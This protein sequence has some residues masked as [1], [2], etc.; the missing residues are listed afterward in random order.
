M[1]IIPIRRLGDIGIITDANPYDLP[2]NALSQ[3]N[4]LSFHNGSISRSPLFKGILETSASAPAFTF[5]FRVSGELDRI[6]IVDEN[7][8]VYTYLGGVETDV[9]PVG[10]TPVV[11]TEPHTFCSL[12]NIGYLNR[13]TDVPMYIT[14][15]A[16]TFTALANWPATY[17]CKALRSFKSYLVALN[18]NKGSS[19]YPTMVKWSDITVTN[20]IPT[21]WDETDP[22]K[23]AGEIP[24]DELTSPLLDGLGLRDAFI[25]YAEDQVHLME[26]TA[27]QSVFRFRKLF[28]GKGIINTNC[29]VEVDGKHFVFGKNDIYVHDGVSSQSIIA[30]K[31]KDFVFNNLN[32]RLSDS[33]FVVHNIALNEIMF[34]YVSGDEYAGYME[35]SL[36]NR[37]AVYNPTNGTWAFRDLPNCSAAT[38]ATYSS[39]STSWASLSGPWD[40][41]GGSWDGFGGAEAYNV[42]FVSNTHTPSGVTADRLLG[43]DTVLNGNINADPLTELNKRAW[44]ERIGIDMDDIGEQIRA[45]KVLNTVYPQALNR[46][47]TDNLYFSFAATETNSPYPTFAPFG[48]NGTYFNPDTSYKINTKVGGR[49]LA[50]RLEN[51]TLSDMQLSGFDLDIIPTGR[52]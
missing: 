29:V 47:G 18:I 41:L 12:G 23:S 17:T 51:Y 30:G 25:C 38:N 22:T 8:E 19:A 26:Y 36:P 16:T 6:G 50:W 11:S 31:N 39:V 28:D 20:S 21:S 35:T 27:D 4:N 34:C 33:F 3:G 45:Y 9:T 37:A 1:A 44:A 2:P 52:R 10:F 43:Y 42:F 40:T 15:S 13:V 48:T 24:L 7:G 49:Y 14:P 5:A 46:G 32:Q